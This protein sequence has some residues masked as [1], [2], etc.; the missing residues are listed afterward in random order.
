MRKLVALAVG[1]SAAISMAVIAAGH[2]N[3]QGPLDVTGEPYGQAATLLKQQGYTAVFGGAVGGD[4]P[5]SQCIVTNQ[6]IRPVM[7]PATQR[8]QLML[9][10]TKAAQPAPDQQPAGA[11]G[12]VPGAPN[13]NPGPPH[14]GA[15]GITTVTPTPVAGP[16]PQQ[17]QPAG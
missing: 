2:A 7:W 10:C 11:P 14:V 16:P 4:V 15:N 6:K 9:N 5:Q 8:V 1:S 13:Q 12:V 17:A 3:S